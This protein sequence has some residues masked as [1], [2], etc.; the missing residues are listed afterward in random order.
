MAKIL[1]CDKMDQASIDEMKK[2][3]EVD[4]KTG[5]TPEEL[6]QNIAPYHAVVVRSATKVLAPAIDAGVNLKVVIRGGVGIDN[7]DAAYAKEKGI[8]VRNTPG[9]SSAAVAELALGHMFALARHIHKANVTM[10]N[11]EWKKKE[12][13]GIELAGKTLGIIGIGRIGKSL[14]EKAH[15]L[16]MKIIAY[17]IAVKDAP[18]PYIEMVSFDD[19]LAKSDFVSLHIPKKKD[20]GYVIGEAE[21]AKMKN[22]A[23]LINT[24]RG[25]V[26]DEKALF[27]ALNSGKLMGAGIDVWEKEPTENHELASHDKVCCTPHLGASSKEAQERIGGE[28]IEILKEY[29]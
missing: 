29:F 4:V 22:G 21:I 20:G 19:L 15:A 24:A 18:A 8:D 11:K 23:F 28:V 25:G 14:A 6:A 1:I 7:I 9:A 5:Q 3:W 13:E 12:Y 16:G 17:D 10:R 27:N 26:V 2:H